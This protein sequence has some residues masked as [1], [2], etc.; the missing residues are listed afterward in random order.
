MLNE[1]TRLFLSFCQGTTAHRTR[2]RVGRVVER[3]AMT[4]T[5]TLPN[6]E[7]ITEDEIVL[8]NGYPYRLQ[9]VDGDDYEFALSPLYWGG[10]GMDIPFPDRDALVEQWESDSRGTLT[11]EEWDGWIRDARRDPQFTD[12]EIDEI[13]RQLGTTETT[14]GPL[15]RLRRLLGL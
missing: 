4:R 15:D 9:F 1:P 12:D 2:K 5:L 8:Y 13:A 6:G 3:N 10:S 14:D 11:D 7:E